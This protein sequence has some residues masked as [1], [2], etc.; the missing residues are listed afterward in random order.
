MMTRK[1]MQLEKREEY[2]C[3]LEADGI[4]YGEDDD[5]HSCE[6]CSHKTHIGTG[7]VQE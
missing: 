2:T 5:V 4:C 1:R 3:P 7:F 6:D